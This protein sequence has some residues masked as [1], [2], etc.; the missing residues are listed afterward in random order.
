[1]SISV[2][3]KATNNKIE[4]NKGQYNLDKHTAKI[5]ALSSE[6][7]GKYEFVTGKD[8]LPEKNLLATKSCSNQKV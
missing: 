5:S 6:N 1:M 8:V 2:K 7:V 4:Q 3:I